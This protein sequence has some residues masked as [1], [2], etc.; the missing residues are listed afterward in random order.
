M[1][2][3]TINFKITADEESVNVF[4]AMLSHMECCSRHGHS[5]KFEVFADGD[6]AIRFSYD[7]DEYHDKEVIGY[8]QKTNTFIDNIENKGK[9][10]LF[11]YPEGLKG[12]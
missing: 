1:D 11:D 7:D 10:V 12:I 4:M 8:L 2:K 5:S 9:H 3:V 6:G